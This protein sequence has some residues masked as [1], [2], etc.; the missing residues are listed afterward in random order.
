MFPG[1]V[2]SGVGTS[3]TRPLARSSANP[4][5]RLPTNTLIGAPTMS[6]DTG[7]SEDEAFDLLRTLVCALGRAD[8]SDLFLEHRARLT[9]AHEGIERAQRIEPLLSDLLRKHEML[10]GSPRA[11][12]AKAS[13]LEHSLAQRLS[14]LSAR[15]A[16]VCA[17]ILCGLSS[18][19]IAEDLG[20]RVPTVKTFR[21]RAYEKLSI[22]SQRQLFARCADLM[23]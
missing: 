8:F 7:L 20:V 9:G 22:N 13:W 16:Q 6:A 2:D 18:E 12:Y 4:L 17:R 19:A 23:L 1:T 10:Q 14:M 21:K 3:I 5:V 11:Q 15:E